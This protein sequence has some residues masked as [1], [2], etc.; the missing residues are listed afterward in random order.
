MSVNEF[1]EKMNL[2]IDKRMNS[3]EWDLNIA[4]GVISARNKKVKRN[5]FSISSLSL[6]ATAAII[7]I[8]FFVSAPSVKINDLDV[9]IAEQVDGTHKEVFKEDYSK[10][11]LQINSK[12]N[13]DGPIYYLV[14][15]A[16]S[17]R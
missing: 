6:L 9:F 7:V 10:N 11:L 14:D 5:I 4:A 16:L 1:H 12:E 8:A 13:I 2:E 17:V 15:T 3:S